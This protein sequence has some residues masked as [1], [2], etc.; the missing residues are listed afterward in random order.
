MWALDR[1]RNPSGSWPD[2]LSLQYGSVRSA[3]L[4]PDSQ[5]AFAKATSERV[6]SATD[7]VAGTP[8]AR[9]SR[10]ACAWCGVRMSCDAF[11]ATPSLWSTPGSPF[12]DLVA[13]VDDTSAPTEYDVTVLGEADVSPHA[14]LKRDAR[15]TLHHGSVYILLGTRRLEPAENATPLYVA[16]DTTEIFEIAEADT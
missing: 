16:T 13:R 3:V 12:T 15:W 8:V 9:P 10:E 2:K 4:L 7:S 5:A 11:R 14:R 1:G 6:A